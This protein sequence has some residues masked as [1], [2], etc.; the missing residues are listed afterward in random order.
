MNQLIRLITKYS[1]ILAFSSLIGITWFYLKSIV[2]PI[3]NIEDI[4]FWQNL[5]SYSG[6]FFKLLISILLFIDVNKFGLKFYL[7]PIVG[8]FYPLLGVCALL[9]MVIY[10]ENKKASAQHAL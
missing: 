7:I 5:P 6:Y 9:I 4:D 10:Y 1:I 2:M 3:E 8:L